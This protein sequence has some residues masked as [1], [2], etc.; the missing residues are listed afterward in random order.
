MRGNHTV[1]AIAVCRMCESAV[2]QHE[3]RVWVH[4]KSGKSQC[5]TTEATPD[6]GT[7]TEVGANL[8][9][10]GEEMSQELKSQL[11]EIKPGHPIWDEVWAKS[12]PD[13]TSHLNQLF[14][15]KLKLAQLERTNAA[16]LGALKDTSSMMHRNYV[17]EALKRVDAA[18]AE[19]ESQKE[20]G[21]G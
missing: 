1:V 12:R 6:K 21:N 9:S 20:N 14:E 10:R 19:A 11:A 17:L 4:R 13:G 16:L 7:I 18:I 8:E 3:D 2:E 15:A 5:E